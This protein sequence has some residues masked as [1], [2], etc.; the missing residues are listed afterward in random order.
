MLLKELSSDHAFKH[1]SR[2]AST[3]E[4]R[5]TLVVQSAMQVRLFSV[6]DIK[7]L[8]KLTSIRNCIQPCYKLDQL[9]KTTINDTATRTY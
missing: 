9:F 8:G 2:G 6:R 1:H 7:I 5:T 3:R 4:H